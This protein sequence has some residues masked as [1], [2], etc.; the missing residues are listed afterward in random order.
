MT[1]TSYVY[2]SLVQDDSSR[3]VG[4][5]AV[6]TPI[7]DLGAGDIQVADHVPLGRDHLA[8]AVAAALEDGVIVQGPGDRGQGCTLHITHEGHWLCRAHHFLA[9]GGNDFGSS[10]C[11]ETK[12][13]KDIL[14][15]CQVHCLYSGERERERALFVGTVPKT[16]ALG[17]V[18][19]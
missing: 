13:G 17:K 3:V 2:S 10:V 15:L 1:S 19:K 8:D 6:D 18:S 7:P 11:R 5:A 4:S 12:T 16:L 9:K 14:I